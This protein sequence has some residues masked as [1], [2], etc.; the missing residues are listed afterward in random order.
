M[1]TTTKGT[2]Q[3]RR[4]KGDGSIFKNKRGGWT[5]RYRKKGLPDKEFNAPTKGEAK[6]LLDEWKV[7]IAIQ[8]AITTNIKVCDYAQ[9]YLFRKLLCVEAGNYKQ[10]SL[11]RLERTYNTHIRDTDA[12]KKSFTNLTADDITQTIN[13][14]KE[15]LSYSSL[16]K[17]Y[18]FWS[19]LVRH[20][21]DT[22]ELPQNYSIMK[23]VIMPAENSLIV[24]TK[25]IQ[26]I[27]AK[28]IPIIEEIAMMPSPNRNE[29]FLYRYGPAIVFL[30]H[31][32]LRGGELLGLG[33]TKILW[34][35]KRRCV[36]IDR[37]LNR[38]KNR[39][40]GTT[41]KTKLVLT[42]PKYPNSERIVPLN[43]KA[44]FCLQCMLDLYDTNYFDNDL[45]L[46]TQNHLSPTLQ[47][48][49]NTLIKICRRAGI[50]EYSLHALRHTFATN[51]VRNTTNMGELKDA[52]ELLGDSY[53]VILKTYFHTDTQNKM[54]LVDAIA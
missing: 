53:E 27:D 39:D 34:R 7:K 42:A 19:A 46:T 6:K 3:K 45:I 8:D 49:R 2:Q 21:K 48:L 51:I 23:S 25:E 37:T 43:K 15:E 26:I 36:K 50:Q 52:A 38:V 41:A 35:D 16:K 30:L 18:L 14:K 9:K 11:D 17:I 40:K 24:E 28:D 20:A 5:A 1:A 33:R 22:G 47:N 32:G 10:S 4:S 13:A 44:D 31:T 29:Q 12:A 54:A